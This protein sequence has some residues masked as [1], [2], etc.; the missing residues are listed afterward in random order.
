M[1]KQQIKM[2]IDKYVEVTGGKY[3]LRLSKVVGNSMLVYS[4]N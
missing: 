3:S 2:A 1:D 4:N